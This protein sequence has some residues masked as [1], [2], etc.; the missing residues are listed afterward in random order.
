MNVLDSS[1]KKKKAR[2]VYGTW[3]KVCGHKYVV[4]PANRC[5]KILK[6]TTVR[7]VFARCGITISLRCI[8]EAREPVPA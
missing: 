6:H 1:Q 7:R 8:E 5:L 2:R 3:P 4:L